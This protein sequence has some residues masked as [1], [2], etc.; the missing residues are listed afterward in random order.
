M[1][2]CGSWLIFFVFVS[3]AI[4]TGSVK[5]V[6]EL[7][8]KRHISE[9]APAYSDI[10]MRS[11]HIRPADY[12]DP[13]LK[14]LHIKPS[15]KKDPYNTLEAVRNFHVNYLVWSYIKDKDFIEKL[16]GMGC[17]FGNANSSL[18]VSNSKLGNTQKNLDGEPVTPPWM[19][20]W[21]PK[22]TSTCVNHPATIDSFVRRFSKLISIGMDALQIDD[23]Q[24]NVAARNYG[25]CY[26]KYCV[27]GFREYLIGK[28]LSDEKLAE[29]GIE[30]IENFDIR[31]YLKKLRVKAG[32]DT[33]YSDKWNLNLRD[34]YLQFQMESVQD[35]MEKVKSK[36]EEKFVK[37]L[38]LSFNNGSGY[39]PFFAKTVYAYGIGEYNIRDVDPQKIYDKI[40]EISKIGKGQVFTMPKGHALVLPEHEPV[41]RKFIAMVYACGGQTLMPWD[42]YLS[43]T[44]QGSK[45]YFGKYYDYADLSGFIRGAAE[46]FEG[47]ELVTASGYGIGKLM[48]DPPVIVEADSSLTAV[49]RAKTKQADAAVVVHL[50]NWSDDQSPVEVILNPKR[51]YGDNPIKVSLLTPAEYDAAEHKKAESMKDYS[52]LVEK[53]ILAEGKIN[54]IKVPGLRTWGILVIE[55]SASESKGEVWAP[56]LEDFGGKFVKSQKIKIADPVSDCSIHYTL[57]NSE[58]NQ[59]SPAFED[60]IE[61]NDSCRFKALAFKGEKK[62]SLVETTFIKANHLKSKDLKNVKPGLKAKVKIGFFEDFVDFSKIPPDKEGFIKHITRLTRM[63][64]EAQQAAN[65]SGYIKVSG[66]GFYDFSVFSNNKSMETKI[67]IDGKVACHSKNNY[68]LV[69][70]QMSLEKGFHEIKIEH[71]QNEESNN[72]FPVYIKGPGMPYTILPGDMLFHESK[73]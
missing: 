14:D 51:F 72:Y 65:A 27:K 41:I 73:D 68:Q 28:D 57:D 35:T 6:Y 71:Y 25:G 8:E 36:L 31:K 16:H 9:G 30:D 48:N 53:T 58:P 43:S 11:L 39:W 10:L 59:K 61:I 12:N 49:V 63:K 18:S 20:V 29:L 5:K 38:I 7:A 40:V 69:K 47:Y 15:D 21:D 26:C 33:F 52:N 1:K 60:P 55:R 3:T 70:R 34:H 13:L 66:D 64:S 4:C 42:I 50:V 67:Y 45:R 19:R 46:L 17:K 22:P 32:D 56:V 54:N 62:S 23:P 44:P 24:M 2:K 37:E